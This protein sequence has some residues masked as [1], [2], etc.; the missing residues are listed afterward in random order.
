MDA[1]EPDE[2]PSTVGVLHTAGGTCPNCGYWNHPD[3]NMRDA[4]DQVVFCSNCQFV[5]SVK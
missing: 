1:P 5:W 4:G 2:A 3:A